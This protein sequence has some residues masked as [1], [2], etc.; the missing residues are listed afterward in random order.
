MIST[1]FG[2]TGALEISI[3]ESSSL[4]MSAGGGGGGGA[5]CGGGGGGADGGGGGGGKEAESGWIAGRYCS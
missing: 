2:D 3:I 1:C 4:G 5:V